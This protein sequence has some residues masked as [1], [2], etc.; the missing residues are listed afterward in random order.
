MYHA[1]RQACRKDKC[2]HFW[3]HL[4]VKLKIQ[5]G[6]TGREISQREEMTF[7]LY[8]PLLCLCL[9]CC[10]LILRVD[11]W[12]RKTCSRRSMNEMIRKLC[13]HSQ[14]VSRSWLF[15]QIFATHFHPHL[16][17][18]R[19]T[20]ASAPRDS[21]PTIGKSQGNVSERINI[22]DLRSLHEM[23]E[24]TFSANIFIDFWLIETIRNCFR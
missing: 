5:L 2:F 17:T 19:K 3:W 7:L 20:A 21:R 4:P 10:Q 24:K 13:W 18:E 11:R 15:S 8:S 22:Q 23:N 14:F 6:H 1:N 12:R 16:H 9:Q